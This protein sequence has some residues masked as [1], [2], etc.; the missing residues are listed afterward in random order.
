M[1]FFS[2]RNS[3]NNAFSW[4][5][6]NYKNINL[7]SCDPDAVFQQ[8]DLLFNQKNSVIS[9]AVKSVQAALHFLFLWGFRREL[10]D[11]GLCN[12]LYGFGSLFWG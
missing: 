7:V 10:W 2:K 4:S 6:V 12:I 5:I 11:N 3:W 9:M 8:I 1:K